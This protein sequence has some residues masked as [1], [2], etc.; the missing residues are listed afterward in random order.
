MKL[1]KSCDLWEGGQ[2]VSHCKIIHHW[3]GWLNRLGDSLTQI[4][5]KGPTFYQ[6]PQMPPHG[7]VYTHIHKLINNC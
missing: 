4:Q 6:K 2:E 7:H 3:D 1:L 5:V